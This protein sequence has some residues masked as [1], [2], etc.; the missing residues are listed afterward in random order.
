ML[1]AG[2]ILLA[3]CSALFIAACNGAAFSK[4]IQAELRDVDQVETFEENG[5]ILLKNDKEIERSEGM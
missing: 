5:A 3:L 2:L 1:R 4:E